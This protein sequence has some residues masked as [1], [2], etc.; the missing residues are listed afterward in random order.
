MQP[1]LTVPPGGGLLNIRA[2]AILPKDGRFLMA[3]SPRAD[4]LSSVGG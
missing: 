3:G 1:N 2:G 4:C